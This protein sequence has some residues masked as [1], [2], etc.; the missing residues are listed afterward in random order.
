MF[1][2]RSLSLG[3]YIFLY[4][5]EIAH[6][7]IWFRSSLWRL[8][9]QFRRFFLLIGRKNLKPLLHL[10]DQ[11]IL[12]LLNFHTNLL[13]L[14]L[15]NLRPNRLALTLRRYF[16]D[17]Q[18]ILLQEI[19]PFFG[20]S[21]F[22][23]A[24]YL[25]ECKRCI[26][27][28]NFVF[29]GV[30][31]GISASWATACTVEVF[32]EGLAITMALH[33]LQTTQ[34]LLISTPTLP[35]TIQRQLILKLHLY[36]RWCYWLG[37]STRS[38]PRRRLPPNILDQFFTILICQS[39][40]HLGLGYLVTY[41]STVVA[42][43][44]LQRGCTLIIVIISVII[45]KLVIIFVFEFCSIYVWSFYWLYTFWCWVMRSFYLA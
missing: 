11:T 22:W 44:L 4:F 27:L 9:P 21:T 24:I 10:L 25:T 19:I 1:F 43:L 18:V 20:L 41:K 13:Q 8:T 38:L 36:N 29:Y 33:G 45:V 32:L 37:T 3:L 26:V 15:G 23:L 30:H 12:I 7:I 31:G 5:L 14:L 2:F 42:V 34:H 28:G 17:V 39:F 35:T 6:E 40:Y 16:L